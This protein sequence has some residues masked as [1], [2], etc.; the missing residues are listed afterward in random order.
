MNKS[1][2]ENLLHVL[3]RF[4]KG[5]DCCLSNC[6]DDDLLFSN[7]WAS[8]SFPI[9]CNLEPAQ[10]VFDCF[11]QSYKAR[12]INLAYDLQVKSWKSPSSPQ[13]TQSLHT[14][15]HYELLHHAQHLSKNVKTP[16][17]NSDANT[18]ACSLL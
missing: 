10:T 12:N 2:F 11:V 13:N 16:N 5:N 4:S 7:S 14:S 9:S 1:S 6:E 3:A 18:N 15:L 17:T 8:S